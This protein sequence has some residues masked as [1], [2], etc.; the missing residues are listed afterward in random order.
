MKFITKVND[1]N[2]DNRSKNEKKDWGYKENIFA[3]IKYLAVKY[4]TDFT[5]PLPFVDVVEISLYQPIF[6]HVRNMVGNC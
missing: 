3:I 5:L 6:N 4:S 2:K 1:N